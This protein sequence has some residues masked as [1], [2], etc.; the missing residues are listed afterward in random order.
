[1]AL[2]RQ[3]IARIH[4]A[5]FKPRRSPLMRHEYSGRRACRGVTGSWLVVSMNSK[6]GL[7]TQSLL[8]SEHHDD[9]VELDFRSWSGH[10]KSLCSPPLPCFSM[11]ILAANVVITYYQESAQAR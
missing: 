8:L 4:T 9:Q 2:C 3:G 11:C 7:V 10:S 1:M 5:K 6:L